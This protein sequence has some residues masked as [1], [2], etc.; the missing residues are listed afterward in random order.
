M[1]TNFG[2]LKIFKYKYVLFN[3]GVKKLLLYFNNPGSVLEDYT[4]V[5]NHVCF[6]QNQKSTIY[7]IEIAS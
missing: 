7:S 6:T 2:K 3:L 1:D 5:L 4:F